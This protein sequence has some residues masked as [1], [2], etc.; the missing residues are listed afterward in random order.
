MNFVRMHM[1][2][3]WSDDHSIEAVRYEGH[4]RFSET[5]FIKYLDECSS[6]WLNTRTVRDYTWSSGHLALVPKN[7]VGM[8]IIGSWKSMGHRLQRIPNPEQRGIMFELANEPIHIGSGRYLR[9]QRPGAFRQD[10]RVLPANNRHDTGQSEQHHLGAR[11]GLPIVLQWI[12]EQPGKGNN[13]GYMH[14][15]TPDGTAVIPRRQV[16]SWVVP[17]EGATKASSGDGTLKSSR[18]PISRP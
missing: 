6:R 5:R 17:W 13:I 2:P 10:E 15:P 3:Y 7:V 1:D 14:T 12:R 18:W 11:V 4:E 16:P 9:K 8:I